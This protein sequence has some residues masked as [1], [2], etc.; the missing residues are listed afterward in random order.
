MDEDFK[1]KVH[2]V[3]VVMMELSALESQIERLDGYLEHKGRVCVSVDVYE[4][5]D[6]AGMRS[7]GDVVGLVPK[8]AVKS[9]VDSYARRRRDELMVRFGEIVERVY[10]AVSDGEG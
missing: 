3:R 7:Y 1:R 9:L 6:V 4:G 5:D 2:R 8:G 10:N